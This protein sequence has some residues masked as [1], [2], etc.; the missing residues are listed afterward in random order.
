[1]HWLRGVV[2]IAAYRDRYGITSR[3]PLGGQPAD[4]N[5][6][7]DRARAEVALRRAT[8]DAAGAV[9]RAQISQRDGLGM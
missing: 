4:D 5:Q 2:T 9:R 3:N 1:M 6:R 8:D 7:L